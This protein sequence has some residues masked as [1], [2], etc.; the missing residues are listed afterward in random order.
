VDRGGALPWV[1]GLWKELE[2]TAHFH[3][4][5]RLRM[6]GAPITPQNFISWCG[7]DKFVFLINVWFYFVTSIA[8]REKCTNVE[9]FQRGKFGFPSGFV[10][11][12][13]L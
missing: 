6:S 4:A 8:M 5:T 1:K 12:H 9:I 11:F 10:C 3:L 13:V 2:L 7:K